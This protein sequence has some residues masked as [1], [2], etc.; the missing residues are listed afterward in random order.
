MADEFAPERASAL[1]RLSMAIELI[2][3]RVVVSVIAHRGKAL[4]PLPADDLGGQR[5]DL[6]SGASYPSS[7]HLLSSCARSLCERRG[8]L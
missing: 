4:F 2:A 3:G 5:I 8:D 7:G 6:G 1:D